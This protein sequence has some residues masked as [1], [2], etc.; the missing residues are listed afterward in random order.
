MKLDEED[1]KEIKRL[2]ETAQT[3]P[4]ITLGVGTK[5]FAEG[6]WD[7]VREKMD[8][9]SKKYGFDPKAMKGIDPE[10][11]EIKL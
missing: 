5:S 8:E 11:G 3:T 2:Y 6:A 7:N 1:R 4:V 10:T 9:L